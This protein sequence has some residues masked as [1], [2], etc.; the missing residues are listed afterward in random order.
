MVKSTSRHL[1]YYR[2]LW[3][4]GYEYFLYDGVYSTLR[5][6][7]ILKKKPTSVQIKPSI[8][9]GDDSGDEEVLWNI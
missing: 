3:T 1:F 7:L 8:F 6:G 2:Q 4:G 9:G 5:Y